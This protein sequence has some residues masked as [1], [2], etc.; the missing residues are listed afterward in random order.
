MDCETVVGRGCAAHQGMI[1][2]NQTT[3]KYALNGLFCIRN[4]QG[5]QFDQLINVLK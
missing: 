5:S 2:S 3:L 1:R 4:I